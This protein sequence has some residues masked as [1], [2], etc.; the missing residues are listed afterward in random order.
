MFLLI[1]CFCVVNVVADISTMRMA[2][3]IWTCS[4]SA[5]MNLSEMCAPKIN[6]SAACSASLSDMKPLPCGGV[7]SRSR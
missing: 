3:T 7:A 6:A 1:S 4:E 2:Q 5:P